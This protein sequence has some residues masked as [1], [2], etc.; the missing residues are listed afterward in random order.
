MDV[1]TWRNHKITGLRR[2]WDFPL[3]KILLFPPSLFSEL[4]ARIES[5]NPKPEPMCEREIIFIISLTI[6]D[7]WYEPYCTHEPKTMFQWCRQALVLPHK[8]TYVTP[9]RITELHN[10]HQNYR[11]L[12]SLPYQLPKIRPTHSRWL[13]GLDTSVSHTCPGSIPRVLVVSLLGRWAKLAKRKNYQTY[14]VISLFLQNVTDKA[15]K[16]GQ[17]RCWHSGPYGYEAHITW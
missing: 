10:T 7:H 6:W 15:T 12:F 16:D 13:S 9:T 17:L 5:L 11:N 8:D 1:R 2:F 3:Y 14:G 4:E